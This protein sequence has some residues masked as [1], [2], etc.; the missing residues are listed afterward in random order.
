MFG[1][2]GMLCFGGANFE[3]G[4]K[5][6]FANIDTDVVAKE[7]P[8]AVFPQFN[9]L[10]ATFTCENA[11]FN[12]KLLEDLFGKPTSYNIEFTKYIPVRHHKKKRINKKWLKRYGYKP[13]RVMSEGWA[14]RDVDGSTV[15]LIKKED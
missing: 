7:E 5:V 4:H 12:D 15:E 13:V 11:V 1:V 6:N 14:I 9:G 2:N 10:E 3:T 8:K